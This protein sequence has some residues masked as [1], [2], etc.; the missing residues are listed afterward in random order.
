MR[1]RRL[2][3]SLE[4]LWNNPNELFTVRY[5]DINEKY[6]TILAKRIK[7]TAKQH[8]LKKPT[9]PTIEKI[10]EA[11]D[12]INPIIFSEM[13][14][15]V[16]W[17]R[18]HQVFGISPAVY[19]A[20]Y[21]YEMLCQAVYLL[22]C[23]K[24]ALNTKQIIRIAR[25]TYEDYEAA[26][27]YVEERLGIAE[28]NEII[29]PIEN[30]GIED[31]QRARERA[32]H[33]RGNIPNSSITPDENY[34][35]IAEEE[36]NILDL[37]ILQRTIGNFNNEYRRPVQNAGR[38]RQ[39]RTIIQSGI[40]MANNPMFFDVEA[41]NQPDRLR[42]W[43]ERYMPAADML[44]QDSIEETESDDDD[45]GEDDDDYEEDTVWGPNPDTRIFPGRNETPQQPPTPRET[46]PNE[47]AI[48]TAPRIRDHARIDIDPGI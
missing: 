16:D 39:E 8:T 1:E 19:I 29:T 14:R 37:E 27:N 11:L 25:L 15:R 40:P 47:Y 24:K 38:I 3:I 36:A 46:I 41:T 34:D 10:Q 45:F 32:E 35:T 44:I 12:E 31:I 5:K 7:A 4:G 17:Y 43:Q 21:R 18:G 26:I 6:Q 33:S 22:T 23:R 28:D 30:L 9:G 48:Y 42:P 2:P 13:Q 20:G